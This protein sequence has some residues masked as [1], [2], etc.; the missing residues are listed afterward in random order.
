MAQAYLR[1][2]Q[3]WFMKPPAGEKIETINERFDGATRMFFSQRPGDAV[4]LLV[5]LDWELQQEGEM[6]AEIAALASL[7]VRFEPRVWVMTRDIPLAGPLVRVRSLYDAP[8]EAASLG[9]V[10]RITREGGEAVLIERRLVCDLGSGKWIDAVL[11]L[12][13]QFARLTPGR[14][15]LQIG[16]AGRES[17]PVDSIF[18]S[19]VSLDEVRDELLAL[20]H[21]M[22]GP[23]EAPPRSIG[24]FRGRL[25]LLSDEPS[26][27]RSVGFM[28]NPLLVAGQLQQEMRQLDEN[29]DPYDRRTGDYWRTLDLGE[30]RSV[31]MRIFAP[32]QVVAGRSMPLVIALHGAGGDENMFMDAYGAGA[33]KR[34]AEEY[35][36]VAVTPSTLALSGQGSN[37]DRLIDDVSLSY[38]IDASRVYL[39]GHSLGAVATSKFVVERG[40][41]LAAAACIAGFGQANGGAKGAKLAPTLVVAAEKDPIFEL[42]RL[43]KAVEEAR[44][45]GMPVE[46]RVSAGAGHTLVVSIELPEIVG[47]LMRH[48]R[49]EGAIIGPAPKP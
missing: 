39:L 38:P 45:M 27:D 6:P 28:F 44:A 41:R 35:G 33:L 40:E 49:S 23:D 7:S 14:Y 3:S 30:G 16:V 31:P 20:S 36:F 29:R 42:S 32:P 22:S 24:I 12:G 26:L 37:L 5:D 46:W 47:W 10:L 8:K 21:N 17:V 34:L 4:R 19:A 1:F 9:V 43:Q 15:D 18:V 13:P 48:R 2:E 11:P 25:A